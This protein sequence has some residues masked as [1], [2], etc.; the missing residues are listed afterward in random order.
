MCE[1]EARPSVPRVSQLARAPD[2]NRDAPQGDICA[3]CSMCAICDG[4]L[5]RSIYR[6]CP[7][8]SYCHNY[9]E[10]VELRET[11]CD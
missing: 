10:G 4:Q 7:C 1:F 8:V 11:V 9:L 3:L 6:G 2:G 5:L